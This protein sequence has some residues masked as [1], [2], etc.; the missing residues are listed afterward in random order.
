MPKD[1]N[2]IILFFATDVHGS[3]IQINKGKIFDA[4]RLIPVRISI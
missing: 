2:V 3:G 1:L 4:G